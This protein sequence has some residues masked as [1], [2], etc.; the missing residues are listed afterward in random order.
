MRGRY[1]D[2]ADGDALRR[3]ASM[4]CNMTKPME[5]D[6]FV[7]VPDREAGQRVAE[8]ATRRGYR[9]G[10]V[11]DEVDDA[12]DCYCSKLMV[13]IYDAVCGAQ[14]ELDELSRPVNGYADGWGTDGNLELH[15]G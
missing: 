4:G 13:P 10:V 2:D 15:P 1:P 8:L 12:W 3:V 5:I 7:A 14:S 9:T 11:Y 6:F